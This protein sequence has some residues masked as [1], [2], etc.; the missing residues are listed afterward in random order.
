MIQGR[1]IHMTDKRLTHIQ[2]VRFTEE[3]MELLR[4]KAA[5]EFGSD[6]KSNVGKYIRKKCFSSEE[7]SLEK[8]TKMYQDIRKMKSEISLAT[9]KVQM[10]QSDFSAELFIHTLTD[11]EEKLQ[12]FLVPNFGTEKEANDGNNKIDEHQTE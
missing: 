2:C 8:I 9:K 10:I 3:Q 6:S 12:Q 5:D 1:S 4:A 11:C 7:D